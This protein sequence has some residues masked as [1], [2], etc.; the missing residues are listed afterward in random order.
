MNI[1]TQ[2]SPGMAALCKLIEPIPVAM[3]SN[4]DADGAL[5]SRPMAVLE[6]DASGAVW[7]FVD[8][9]SS[10]VEFLRVVNLSFVD[11]GHGTYVSLSG[12]GEIR[13]DRS[14]VE[15]LWT[16]MAKPWFPEGPASSNL[17]LLKFVPHTAEYWDAPNS[18]MVRMFAMAASVV[19]GK[20]IGM[21][22][23]ATLTDLQPSKESI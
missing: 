7:F 11:P 16:P 18:K 2:T 22:D 9:R 4:I 19:A 1:E 17:A 13:S 10:R 21:G 8:L 23:H 6:V 12:R 3:L 5:V 14:H 20:P 15:R